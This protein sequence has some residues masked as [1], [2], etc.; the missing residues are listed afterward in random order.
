MNAAVG[1]TWTFL[2]FVMPGVVA[3]AFST[4]QVPETEGHSLE[5]PE[6]RFRA[7]GRPATAH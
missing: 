3:I 6:D 4:T 2:V 5:E 1:P 7:A